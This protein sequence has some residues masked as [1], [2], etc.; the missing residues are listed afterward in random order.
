MALQDNLPNRGGQ[1]WDIALRNAFDQADALIAGK[2]PLDHDHGAGG[3]VVSRGPAAGRPAL[4]APSLYIN[5]DDNV[6]EL[7]DGAGA[8]IA[9]LGPPAYHQ[10]ILVQQFFS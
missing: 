10:P 6:T 3:I 2:A 9:V 4:G 7:L 5:T 1:D 8:V